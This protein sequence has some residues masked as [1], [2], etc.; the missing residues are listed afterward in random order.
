MKA[1]AV[2]MNSHPTAPWKDRLTTRGVCLSIER[3]PPEVL[4]KRPQLLY[5][6]LILIKLKG[7]ILK[8]V[9]SCARTLRPRKVMKTSTR[10]DPLRTKV[11]T[12][13][14]TFAINSIGSSTST[15]LMSFS[16]VRLVRRQE[17]VN[18]KLTVPWALKKKRKMMLSS[19]FLISTI[20]NTIMTS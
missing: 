8:R 19:A 3:K 12:S 15:T 10:E 14:S 4:F 18:L 5:W 1:K 13:S 11:Q 20:K 9:S 7:L 16:Q 17:K 2:W 6:V